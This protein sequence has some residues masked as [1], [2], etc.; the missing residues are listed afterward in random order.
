MSLFF[1]MIPVGTAFA[2]IIGSAVFVAVIFAILPLKE[3]KKGRYDVTK[4]SPSP[5]IL[6]GLKVLFTNPAYLFV[7]IGQTPLA[8]GLTAMADWLPAYFSRT[9]DMSAT[10]A[11]LLVGGIVVVGAVAGTFL[12]AV[13]GDLSKRFTK[14]P[15]FFVSY[16]GL[17]LATPLTIAILL[18]NIKYLAC[19]LIFVSVS[20]VYIYVGPINAVLN[21]SVDANSRSRAMSLNLLIVNSCGSSY[22]S[23]VVGAISDSTGK[24]D[25]ALLVVPIMF[26]LACVIWIVAWLVVKQSTAGEVASTV[27]GDPPLPSEGS[28][29]PDVEL[30]SNTL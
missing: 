13:L 5:G 1:A 12:G 21:N 7:V 16:M 8:G 6:Q 20:A 30:D 3:P 17:I 11:G 27:L 14:Q 4:N 15:Y 26:F 18:M 22:S 25:M 23:A 29:S 24:L 28:V 10:L 19:S 9:Y 2:F